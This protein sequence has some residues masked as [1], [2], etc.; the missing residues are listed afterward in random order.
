MLIL[1]LQEKQSKV[2]RS[3]SDHA[4]E[5]TVT[6]SEKVF[7]GSIKSDKIPL[8]NYA[9]SV[10]Y[11]GRGPEAARR[12]SAKSCRKAQDAESQTTLEAF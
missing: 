5:A 6:A 2:A 12:P 10:F 1:V 7:V 11:F 8:P 9:H 4:L 3:I